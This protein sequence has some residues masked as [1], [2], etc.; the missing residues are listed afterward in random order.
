MSV[1]T[2]LKYTPMNRATRPIEEIARGLRIDSRIPALV[3]GFDAPFFQAGLAGYSDGAMR[4]I[5]R[6]HGCPYCITEALLDRTLICGGKGRRKEDPD[7]LEEECGLGDPEDNR[8]AEVGDLHDHPI[9]GQIMGSLPDEMAKASALL[10]SMNYDVIDVNLAC[11]VKKM[12]KAN[13]GGHCLTDVDQSIAILRAVREAVPRN[14]PCTVKLR[15][16]FDDTPDMAARFERIFN[17]A[18]ELGY[19]WATVHCR[20]VQQKYLGPSKWEFLTDLVGRNRDKIIFGSGDVWTV[21]DLFAMLDVTGVHAVA[22]ARGCIGNP[23]IFRQARQ[24]IAGETPTLPTLDEQREALLEHFQLAIALHGERKASKMMR[25][26]GI[27]FSVHHSQAEDVKLEF[28]KCAT[29]EQWR[30]VIDRHYSFDSDARCD[31]SKPLSA[32]AG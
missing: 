19:A 30:A 20:T 18:Y 10:A 22:V 15:R 2:E 5:A 11:P 23:W 6:R 13:R 9:A 12:R 24:L 3:P 21:N 1:E 27:K 25:K 4:L 31:R 14:V 8:I 17:A 7:L 16:A 29:V 26:F 32:V 28:I